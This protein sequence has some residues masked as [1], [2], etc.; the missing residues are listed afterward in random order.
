M[1]LSQQTDYDLFDYDYSNPPLPLDEA[2]KKAAE[3]RA[4]S[5]GSVFYRI[6]PVDSKE[7]GFRV[8]SV[9]SQEAVNDFMS[10]FSQW[11]SRFSI[12]RRSV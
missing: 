7:T 8:V 11:M 3:L 5:G 6:V 4:K 2:M 12:R 9:Q 1:P 10:R